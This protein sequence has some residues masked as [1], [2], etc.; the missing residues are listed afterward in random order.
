MKQL[1]AGFL[2]V[3]DDG[4]LQCHPT[5]K[6]YKDGNWDIPKGHVED[7]EQPFDTAVR[8]LREETGLEYDKLDIEW[9]KELGLFSYTKYKN[10]FVYV[11]KLKSAPDLSKMKC[12][13]T[14]EMPNGRIVPEMDSYRYSDLISG[15]Y[16][17]LQKIFGDMIDKILNK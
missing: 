17:G 15:Y 6:S 10:L 16:R 13:S 14:F 5:G 3:T 7:G 9:E 8:E 4:F 12:V 11:L 1:S 2:I